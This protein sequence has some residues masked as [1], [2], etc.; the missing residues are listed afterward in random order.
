MF[1]GMGIWSERPVRYRSPGVRRRYGVNRKAHR[2]Q[3]GAGT[4]MLAGM[5]TVLAV[6]VTISRQAIQPATA[7]PVKY[8]KTE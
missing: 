4:F 1:T 5:A 3:I 7:R 2:T 6:A 8:L